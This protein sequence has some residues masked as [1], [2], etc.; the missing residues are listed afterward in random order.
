LRPLSCVSSL[1]RSIALV[2][3]DGQQ[4]KQ[5]SNQIKL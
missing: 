3:K 1:N 4:P 2:A 5:R